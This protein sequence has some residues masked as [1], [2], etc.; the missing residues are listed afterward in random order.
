MG[1]GN[2]LSIRIR[3]EPVNNSIALINIKEKFA[4]TQATNVQPSETLQVL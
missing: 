3:R 1:Y 4:Q 2:N